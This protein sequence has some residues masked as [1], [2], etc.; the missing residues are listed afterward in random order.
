MILTLEPVWLV[1]RL[2]V[3]GVVL[4]VDV[5]DGKVLTLRIFIIYIVIEN[6]IMANT[7]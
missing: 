7:M 3:K 1:E 5:I 4:F 6:S 2:G